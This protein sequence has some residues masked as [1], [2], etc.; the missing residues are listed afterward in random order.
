MDDGYY[1]AN[2]GKSYLFYSGKM[3]VVIPDCHWT[4]GNYEW[5]EMKIGFWAWLCQLLKGV[6]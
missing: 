3:Y 1:Y 4:C 5:A 2:T 6:E